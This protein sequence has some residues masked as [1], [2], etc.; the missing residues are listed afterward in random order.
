MEAAV[1]D[2]SLHGIALV[3]PQAAG[4]RD[5]ILGGDRIERLNVEVGDLHLYQGAA[6]VRH[7]GERGDDLVLGVELDCSG[8]DLGELHRRD[9]R[10][11]FAD[12]WQEAENAA[13]ALDI[14]APFRAWVADLRTYLERV[15]DFLDA[16][17]RAVSN[18]DELTRQQVLEQYLEESAPRVVQRLNEAS[19]DLE[20][21]VAHLSDDQHAAHR[22]FCRAQL[23]HL[24]RLAPFM[25]RAHDKPL[26]YA[27]DYEMMNM[28]YRSHAEG[29]SLFA[30]A[31]N[32]YATQEAAARA[33]I[34]RLTYLDDKIR[35]AVAASTR[36]RIRVASIGCGPAQEIRV[37]LE[38]APELGP[39]LEVALIDQEERSIA[40]CE[41]TLAPVAVRSGARIQFIRESIRRLLGAKRLSQALGQRELIYSAGLFDYLSDR[42]FSA[43]L[44]TLYEALS[45]GGLVAVGNVASNNPSRYA[46]EY[47]SDWFL[48]HR[49]A[50]QLRALAAKLTPAPQQICVDSEPLRVNLFLLVYR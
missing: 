12:R 17:E 47:F 24:F 32:L 22:A 1:E 20:H 15:R 14:A 9:A 6:S 31:V 44:G 7:V 28:L 41:R 13:R 19:L 10:R 29:G 40:Y 39:R 34:N 45:P 11:N 8:I 46:M 50:D 35:A 4:Q 27:G 48:I 30:R 2:L 21:L 43:L 16:E 33:N 36:E 5:L 25:R 3:L 38:R 42:S 49:T 23:G 37:L 18:E 26:G